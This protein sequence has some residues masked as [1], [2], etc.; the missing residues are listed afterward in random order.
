LCIA[1]DC[2]PK[3]EV[4]QALSNWSRKDSRI[5]V[6]FRSENGHI[7]AASNSAIELATG[8]FLA[9]MD[10]D[11]L[12]TPNALLEMAEAIGRHPDAGVL[13]SDEDKI[14][15]QNLR[16]SPTKKGGWNPETLRIHNYISHLGVYRT[17]LVRSLGGFRLGM[18]G[19]QDH[20]LVL[21]CSEQLEPGQIVYV[22]EIL[23][24][25]R[26]HEQSTASSRRAKPYAI[27]ARA[28]C[29]AEHKSR[30]SINT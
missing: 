1:D 21:R 24:H 19:A 20:D 2:S 30:M 10:Q 12:I 29:I 23:Y 8:P 5:K 13:Y 4:R 25:W 3:S 28:K 7:S 22:P 16:E 6:V 26:M 27:T 15:T 18:E 17:D 11:D 14:D 9:L